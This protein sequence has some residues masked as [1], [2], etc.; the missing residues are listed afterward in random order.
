MVCSTWT[1]FFFVVV[2]AFKEMNM[3]RTTIGTFILLA[4]VLGQVVTMI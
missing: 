1:M 3:R 2:H 4:A